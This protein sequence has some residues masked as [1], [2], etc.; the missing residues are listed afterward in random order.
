MKLFK[1]NGDPTILFQACLGLLMLVIATPFGIFLAN[2]GP[3][4]VKPRGIKT[5]SNGPKNNYR[6][7]RKVAISETIDAGWSPVGI[8]GDKVVISRTYKR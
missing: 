8:S 2:S 1:K 6:E 3:E 7:F 4:S 5:E